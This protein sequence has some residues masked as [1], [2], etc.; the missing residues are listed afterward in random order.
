MFKNIKGE[1][2]KNQHR[3]LLATLV[4][5]MGADGVITRYLVESSLAVEANPLIRTSVMNDSFLLLKLAG[6]IASAI[7]LSH[8]LRLRP[9]MTFACTSVLVFSYTLIV[10][11]NILVYFTAAFLF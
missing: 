4:C 6:G 11:W 8:S 10:Y 1:L 2:L 9:M 5:L 7:I 3:L